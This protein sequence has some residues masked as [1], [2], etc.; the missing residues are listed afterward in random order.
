MK[1]RLISLIVATAAVAML[2][3]ATAGYAGHR[4]ASG[5][6][7]TLLTVSPSCT[8]C[9]IHQK[10][11][12]KTAKAAG[13]KLTTMISNFDAATQAQQV[14]QAIAQHPDAIVLWP[15]DAN[16]IVPSLL[17]IQK[18][19]IPL[20]ITNSIP[21]A[22]YAKYWRSYT[23]PNDYA[24]G[25]QA[26]KAMAAGFKAKGYG[27]TGN[28]FVVIGVPGTTPAIQ[29][30]AGFTETLKKVAPGIHVLGSQP[31]KW[32]QT[33]ATD[34]ASGMF[35]SYASKN[36]KGVYAEADNMLAGVI[37]AAKRQGLDPKK[38]VLVGSNCSIEGWTNIKAGTQYASVLQSPVD[39]GN[40][41]GKAVV[42]L[43]NG[44][45]LNHTLYLPHPIISQT[46]LATCNAAVG[47]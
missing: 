8:Y 27:T 14:N 31:G 15:V 26:A 22:K 12:T 19:E 5:A 39:D 4:G 32:D 6:H 2:A 17:A 25:V 46:N 38:L 13:I 42:A 20:I 1:R 28:V 11:F 16:A 7:V 45:T 10:A 35:T 36:V 43:L 24:N 21:P 33:A 29:R 23:G 9:A 30:L 40:Y 47:K 34:A 41:A 3:F 18:A 37:V 44:K